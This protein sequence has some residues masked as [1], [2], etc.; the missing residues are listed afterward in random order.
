MHSCVNRAHSGLAPVRRETAQ[1]TMYPAHP[2]LASSQDLSLSAASLPVEAG[3]QPTVHVT[4][5]LSEQCWISKE[6]VG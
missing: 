6:K 2:Q 3:Q 1:I 5:S 4:P